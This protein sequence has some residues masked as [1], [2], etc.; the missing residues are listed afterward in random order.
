MFRAIYG[1]LKRFLRWLNG[2][3]RWSKEAQNHRRDLESRYG[4][5]SGDWEP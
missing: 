4:G 3:S 5:G 2:G 1:Q